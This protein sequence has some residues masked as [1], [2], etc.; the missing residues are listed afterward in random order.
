MSYLI[1]T[2]KRPTEVG[3]LLASLATSYSS[4][5]LAW[6]LTI[7]ETGHKVRKLWQLIQD[8]C[9]VFSRGFNGDTDWSIGS[10]T[11]IEI[12]E[13]FLPTK[14]AGSLPSLKSKK[15][16]AKTCEC[17]A[18][19]YFLALA[20]N[21]IWLAR[22][23]RITYLEQGYWEELIKKTFVNIQ[24]DRRKTNLEVI[25]GSEKINCNAIELFFLLNLSHLWI[26]S[27]RKLRTN[28]HAIP[29]FVLWAFLLLTGPTI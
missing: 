3:P 19:M 5:C 18:I 6:W 29:N 26:S 17:L 28:H 7:M 24:L 12:F 15:L 21:N 20:G 11:S 14:H 23:V 13:Y 10:T 25:W 2:T 1:E 27:S 22:A 9:S 8:G 4:W 16:R